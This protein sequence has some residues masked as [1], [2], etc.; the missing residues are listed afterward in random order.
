MN[1]RAPV[2]FQLHDEPELPD[3][4]EVLRQGAGG[5]AGR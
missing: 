1:E 3:A 5:R 4:E 2:L